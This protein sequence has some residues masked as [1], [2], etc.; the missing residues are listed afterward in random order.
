[1]EFYEKVVMITGAA[2]TIG[3]IICKRFQKEGATLI[4]I[5]NNEEKLEELKSSLDTP[6]NTLFIQAD[7]RDE[8]QVEEYVR[9]SV[10]F[11]GGIDVLVHCVGT[12]GK[13]VPSR[14]ISK[15]DMMDVYET[16][17]VTSVL[18]YKHVYPVMERQKKGSILFISAVFGSRGIPFFSPYATA[19]HALLGFMKSAALESAPAGVRVNA[20]CP[21]PTNSSM[22]EEV[23]KEVVIGNPHM[24][25]HNI[26]SLIPFGRY[27]E[28]EEVAEFIL[29]L[30][31]DRAS[32]ATGG[33]YAVDGGM[34]AK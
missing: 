33:S 17:V 31:S 27:V 19:S 2:G 28:P 4:L 18:N 26:L 23:E 3:K 5:D 11:F 10:E 15:L 30:A 16:N 22:M 24:T 14:D 9:K 20:V 7:A 32:F 1:M 21:A 12:Y 8:K 34:L 29:F 6:T 25:H 13:I